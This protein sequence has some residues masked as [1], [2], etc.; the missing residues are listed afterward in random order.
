ML[1]KSK[2]PFELGSCNFATFSLGFLL[3]QMKSLSQPLSSFSTLPDM[4]KGIICMG[5]NNLG[6]IF[7]LMIETL[8]SNDKGSGAHLF[9]S[10]LMESKRGL[11]LALNI[12]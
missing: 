3:L 6:R 4:S 8:L 12:S 7:I 1:G 2:P 11:K 9:R 10:F 5:Y